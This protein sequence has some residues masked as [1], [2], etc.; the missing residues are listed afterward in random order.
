MI[1]SDCRRAQAAHAVQVVQGLGSDLE[2]KN[3]ES[4]A[5]L[6]GLDRKAIQHFV[7]ES[8]WDDRPLRDELVRQVAD[9]LGE[10]AG[11]IVFDPSGFEKS[12]KQSVGV[13]RQWCGRLGKIDNC[14]VG[15][16]MAYV[17]S[18]GHTLVDVEI[19]LPHEWTDDKSRM[20]KA[21]VPKS[22]QT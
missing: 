19:S 22:H 2:A 21:G 12:G 20:N 11:V 9:E 3:A 5:Y 18:Q 8:A 14:Q 13:A 1:E 15:V 4:L 17:S 10:P 7:G 16:Y 6:F